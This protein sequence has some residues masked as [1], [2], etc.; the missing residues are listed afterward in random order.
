MAGPTKGGRE[1]HPRR[2]GELLLETTSL[3]PRSLIPDIVQRPRSGPFHIHA[4]PARRPVSV[5]STRVQ[6]HAAMDPEPSARSPAANV[7]QDGAAG[8]SPRKKQKRNKPTLSCEECV[9]RKTKVCRCARQCDGRGASLL[10]APRMPRWDWENVNA[11]L[12]PCSATAGGPNVSRASSGNRSANT[13][14][15]RTS[16]PLQSECFFPC[17]RTTSPGPRC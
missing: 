5:L 4:A 6:R 7:T 15:S 14:R 13:P 3:S 9:E 16:S 8:P 10:F 11:A 17:A 1:R 12:T 2:S